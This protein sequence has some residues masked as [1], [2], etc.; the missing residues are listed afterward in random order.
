[1]ISG[2]CREVDEKYALLGYYEAS[3]GNFLP[4]FRNN[5]SASSSIP[6]KMGPIGCPE[7]SVR[8]YYYLLRND[9]E[10]RNS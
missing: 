8:N 3:S 5:L 9:P 4:T 6:L 1:M 2:F 7:M 10:E